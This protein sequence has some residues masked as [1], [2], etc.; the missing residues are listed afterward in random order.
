MFF[1]KLPVE[2]GKT[3]GKFVS[4]FPTFYLEIQQYLYFSLQK[5]RS[6]DGKTARLLTLSKWTTKKKLSF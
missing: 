2:F 5:K 3:S 6:R 1:E 4:I